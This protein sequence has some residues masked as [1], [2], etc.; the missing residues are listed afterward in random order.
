MVMIRQEC[1]YV[2]KN[3]PLYK[4]DFNKVWKI[5]EFRIL[6]LNHIANIKQYFNQTWV[7]NIENIIREQIISIGKGWFN[8][9]EKIKET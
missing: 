5:D 2:I 6:Q 7:Q 4:L 3:K 8:M 9:N 1:E